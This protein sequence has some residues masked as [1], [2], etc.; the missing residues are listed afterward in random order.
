MTR[1]KHRR[2]LRSLVIACAVFTLG[3]ST[4]GATTIVGIR[5][6][7]EIVIAADSMGTFR[8]GGGPDSTKPVCKV[9]TVQDVGFAISGL[10]KGPIHGLN[11]EILVADAISRRQS[12][13]QVADAIENELSR[14]I[15]HE[16]ERQKQDELDL[17]SKSVAGEDGYVTSVLLG[18]LEGGVPVAVGI[19]F[20]ASQGAAGRVTV[21][22][23]RLMCPGDCPSGVFT[24]FLGERGPIDNYTKSHGKNMSMP[25]APGARFL[26][27]VV[28][29]AG[30]PTVSAPI[31]VLTISKQGVSWSAVKNGCG[32]APSGWEKPS[33]RQEKN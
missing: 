14:V 31:D 6:P 1:T 12:I 8:G 33:A 32:G 7:D 18:V 22:T 17:F 25:P 30:V 4:A 5:T 24:F 19:G 2:T 29:D 15:R 16:L 28:I 20:K 3:I 23:S 11:A 27:Q 9:F 21:G 13:S 26:V 10:T